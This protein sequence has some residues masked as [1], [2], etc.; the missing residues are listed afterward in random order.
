MSTRVVLVKTDDVTFI[1]PHLIKIARLACSG[2]NTKEI[3]KELNISYR[4]VQAHICK[5]YETLDVHD[6]AS[7]VVECLSRKWVTLEELKQI[8]VT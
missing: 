7:L 2:L 3:A 5:L 1:T 6:R 4:T 8:N